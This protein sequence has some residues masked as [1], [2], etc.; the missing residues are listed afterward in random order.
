[1]DSGSVKN[2]NTY[3][4]FFFDGNTV[5]ITKFV[6]EGLEYK[7]IGKVCNVKMTTSV[8]LGVTGF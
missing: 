2:L 8:Y 7:R 4:F 1:M 5:I 3:F 6:S